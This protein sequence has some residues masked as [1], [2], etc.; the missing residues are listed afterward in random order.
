MEGQSYH[1]VTHKFSFRLKDARD[2]L[3]GKKIMGN[4]QSTSA[5]IVPSFML[6]DGHFVLSENS[7]APKLSSW[8]GWIRFEGH[9]AYVIR[10]VESSVVDLVG[11]WSI[12][13]DSTVRL[14][15]PAGAEAKVLMIREGPDVDT[16][17]V[18]I[19]DDD[20]GPAAI[21]RFVPEEEG[22]GPMGHRQ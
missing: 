6:C 8:C 15:K 17:F 5:T 19:E 7:V 22:D 4:F 11:Q 1:F 3:R 14:S 9:G 12:V 16:L 21:F 18:S 2:P 13:D 10:K 20:Y